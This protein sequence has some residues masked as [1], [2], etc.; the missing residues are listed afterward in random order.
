MH[1]FCLGSNF[2]SS[3]PLLKGKFRLLTRFAPFKPWVQFLLYFW[4]WNNE[5]YET[6]AVINNSVFKYT[7]SFQYLGEDKEVAVSRILRTFQIDAR[8]L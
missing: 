6:E 3:S 2:I 1:T 4:G 8:C 5:M 7:F